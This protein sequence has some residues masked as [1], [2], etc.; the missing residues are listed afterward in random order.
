MVL[1]NPELS[2]EVVDEALTDFRATASGA[3]GTF[4]TS[5]AS[6]W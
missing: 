3:C 6:E 2:D 1:P 4:R 5:G